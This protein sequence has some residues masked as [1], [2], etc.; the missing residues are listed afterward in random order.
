MGHLSPHLR[1]HWLRLKPMNCSALL[2]ASVCLA[3]LLIVGRA[4]R[5]DLWWDTN[6]AAAGAG[7]DSSPDGNWTDPSW[8]SDS[9]GTSATQAWVPGETAAFSA[10]TNGT[11]FY[12]VVFAA[13]INVAGLRREEGSPRLYSNPGGVLTF[14]NGALSVDTGVGDFEVNSLLGPTNGVITKVGSGTL[15]ASRDQTSF[16]GKW[17][18]NEGVVYFASDK[19]IGVV[20]ASAVVDEITINNGAGIYGSGG[21]NRGITLGTGGGAFAGP[22]LGSGSTIWSWYGPITGTGPFVI[23]THAQLYYG[24]SNNNY[25]GDTIIKDGFINLAAANTF[26]ATSDVKVIGATT[27]IL[28]GY[29]QT[30][31]SLSMVGGSYLSLNGGATMT[32]Q[33]PAGET[34]AGEIS[35]GGTLVKN[36]TGTVTL[37]GNNSAYTFTLNNGKVGIGS[38]SAFGA[39]TSNP[40]TINGGTL[41]N[42]AASNRTLSIP[43]AVNGDFSVDNSMNASPGGLS[44]TGVTTFNATHTIT[45]GANTKI[46]LSQLRQSTAGAGFTKE[47]AGTLDLS[48]AS[49]FLPAAISGPISINAGVVLVGANT[50]MGTGNNQLNFGGGMLTTTGNQALPSQGGY[51]VNVSA[52]SMISTTSTQPVVT[53]TFASNS[54]T[55]SG[56]LTFRNDAPSGFGEFR[57]TLG[58]G[59]ASFAPGPIEIANGA[60]GWTSLYSS[61]DQQTFGSVISGTGGFVRTAGTGFGAT[62]SAANTYSGGTSITGGTLLVNNTTGS[63]TG[64]GAVS[65]VG[66][67]L[68]GTGTISGAV[69]NYAKIAPGASANGISIGTF[70]LNNNV[71]FRSGSQLAIQLSG[72]SADKLVVGGDLNLSSSDS[73]FVTGSGTGPWVIATYAGTRT[74]TFDNV[75]SGYVVDYTTPGEI[76]LNSMA[77]PGDYNSDGVVDATDYIAWRKTPNAYSGDPAGFTAWRANYGK[78]AGA[79]SGSNAAAVPEPGM[80]VLLAAMLIGGQLRREVRRFGILCCHRQ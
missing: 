56:K 27:T 15:T 45:V 59:G 77:L 13:N 29:N 71:T 25:T 43:V 35:G 36:G 67:T 20:P 38:D 28:N 51:P 16:A 17:I 6:G 5:G 80:L 40:L 9:A 61:G 10:G 39:S 23:N 70:T 19:S 79:G 55:G 44:F 22:L 65:V 46:S 7:N 31:N 41:A 34:I 60:V 3:G 76:I 26:P 54:I 4:A 24:N 66:G 42:T 12:N 21:T 14:T 32:V 37:T 1:L 48:T 62:L 68:G 18:V 69:T 57:P 11:S 75:T 8:T 74:G 33:N 78:T 72:T 50:I 64:S 47:G 2:A 58:G 52:D 73:L 63:G 49:T 53:M 30:V